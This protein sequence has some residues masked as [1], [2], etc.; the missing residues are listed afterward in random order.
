MRYKLV[1]NSMQAH[2]IVPPTSW[3][4]SDVET[5][6]SEHVSSIMTG[7]VVSPTG[8]LFEKGFDR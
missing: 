1:E 3:T 8:D 6:L 7:N 5:W 2:A 4:T